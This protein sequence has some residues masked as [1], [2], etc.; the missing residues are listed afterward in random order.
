[1][2]Y[3]WTDQ[4]NLLKISMCICCYRRN[5]YRRRWLSS[6][7]YRKHVSWWLPGNQT[8]AAIFATDQ[9]ARAKTIP[10]DPQTTSICCQVKR[11]ICCIFDCCIFDC[12]I[13]QCCIFQCA[14]E[15]V[16]SGTVCVGVVATRQIWGH[17]Q[18]QARTSTYSH[19]ISLV[20]TAIIQSALFEITLEFVPGTNQIV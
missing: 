20:Y 18:G 12:C 19:Y 1:M 15:R 13:F 17:D 3:S 4:W 10:H 7:S 14:T 5:C 6:V 9:N 16:Y 8:N 11:L 2:F